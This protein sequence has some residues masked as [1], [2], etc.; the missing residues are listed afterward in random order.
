[1]S[2]L[3]KRE[4]ALENNVNIATNVSRLECLL[5]IFIFDFHGLSDKNWVD[6]PKGLLFLQNNTNFVLLFARRLIVFLFKFML[7]LIN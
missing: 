2:T 6:F 5:F 3:L 1:M 7:A 4:K